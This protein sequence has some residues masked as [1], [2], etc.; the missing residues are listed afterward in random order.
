M[1]IYEY[2]CQSCA[3]DFE[4]TRPIAQSGEPAPCPTCGKLAQKLVSS[5]ASK[6]DYTVKV[7]TKEPFRAPMASGA[8]AGAARQ[9]SRPQARDQGSRP[10]ARDQGSRPQARDTA[11][12]P[13]SSRRGAGKK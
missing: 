1:P 2:R 5:F 8:K 13:T 3:R 6:A 11:A 10:Q 9:G 7:P 4:M 12:K